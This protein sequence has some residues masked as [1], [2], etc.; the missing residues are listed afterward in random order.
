[1]LIR[2][3]LGAL[4]LSIGLVAQSASAQ[5]L[6]TFRWQLQ[7]YCN[8]VTVNVVQ[9]G[10]VYTVDG[11]DDQC[12]A[13]QRAPLV[14][15]AT[16]NPDGTIGFG[17]NVVTV[18]GGRG[19]QIDARIALAT[20]S[21]TWRDSAGNSGTFAFGASTGGSPR[22]LP[23]TAAS[24]I[25]GAFSLRSDGGFLAAGLT[26]VGTIPGVGPGARMMWYPGKAAFRAGTVAGAQWDDANVGSGSM[27]MGQS[28]VASGYAS[29]ALG[30]STTASGQASTALGDGTVASGSSSTAMGNDTA[31]SG[32]ASTAMGD[33]TV[34]SGASSTAMGD[35]T[36]ASGVSSTAMGSATRASGIWSTAMG[37]S[38]TATGSGSLVA[39]NS[40]GAGGT[41]AIALGL[42][43]NANGTGSV[44]LGSDA[45]AM[46]TGMFMFGDRSTTNDLASAGQNEFLVRAAGGTIFYSNAAMTTG[47]LLA[48][49]TSTWQSLGVSDENRKTDFRDLDSE[50]VLDKLAALP[51]REWRYTTQDAGIRH[52]GP[53]AQDFRAAFGLGESDERIGSVDA[54]GI[55]LAGVK[56][57]DA[58][59]RATNEALSRQNEMLTHAVADLRARL[60]RLEALLDKR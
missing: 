47:V 54:D 27:A 5:S 20:L 11:H 53:T 16:P 14:G 56:A 29:T 43:V 52:V 12:G 36:E 46:T 6:G 4:A 19:V 49:G 44:V 45:T 32:A 30:V 57:L 41:D 3:H 1:M 23:T 58:R 18:P 24:P 2:F 31:A 40:S 25:P 15:L 10:A 33:E 22:P 51:V 21:G 60:A 38:T 42:R 35:E 28:S 13:P 50:L 39:G 59:T 48:A 34:A 7:P 9:Q 26:G 8:V 55:A 17:L 37:V